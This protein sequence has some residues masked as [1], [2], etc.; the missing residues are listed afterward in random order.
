MKYRF[1]DYDDGFDEGSLNEDEEFFFSEVVKRQ[2][3]RHRNRAR[4]E[5][6]V[7]DRSRHSRTEDDNQHQRIARVRAWGIPY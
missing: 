4:G 6:Q 1:R 2:L 7:K 5:A 3:A